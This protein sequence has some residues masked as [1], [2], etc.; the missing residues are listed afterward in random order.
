MYE[1]MNQRSGP[2]GT[3]TGG[4]ELMEERLFGEQREME[5]EADE[6]MVDLL[7]QSQTIRHSFLL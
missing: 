2:W 7:K 3:L 4:R 6:E 5:R 1:Y